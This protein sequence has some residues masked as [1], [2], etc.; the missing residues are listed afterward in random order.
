MLPN[1][2]VGWISILISHAFYAYAMI[3]F[4]I[5]ISIIGA[6]ETTF[7]NNIEPIM[8]VGAGYLFLN[9]NLTMFQYIGILIVLLALLYHGRKVA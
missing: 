4:F 6:G 1:S 7:Y 5:A 3:S 2:S 8:A 9:Q